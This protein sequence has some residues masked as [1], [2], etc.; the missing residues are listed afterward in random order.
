MSAWRALD[1]EVLQ[2]VSDFCLA[3]PAAA[4]CALGGA[5]A[6]AG[7][8]LP[9]TPEHSFSAWTTY[10]LRRGLLIGYGATYQ[11]EYTFA[12]TSTASP[13]FFTDD[14]WVHRAMVSY[15][16]TDHVSLQ[17]NVNNRTDERY[18]IR[19]R[20]NATSGW[21]TPGDGR[22]FVLSTNMRF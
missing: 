10:E 19:V 17:L 16:L 7:D 20:N 3:N 13:F 6:I 18:F 14:Y 21:A 15:P 12:R 4:G 5:N 22:Q 9:V 2:G 1:S 8:P 11:G